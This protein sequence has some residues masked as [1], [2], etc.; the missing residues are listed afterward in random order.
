MTHDR[1]SCPAGV[2]GTRSDRSPE[3]VSAFPVEPDPDLNRAPTH[4]YGASV[5]AA[6]R[7]VVQVAR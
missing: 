1:S 2:A 7:S 6:S 3:V 4:R 5:V